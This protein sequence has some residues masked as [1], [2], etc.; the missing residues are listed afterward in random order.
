MLSWHGTEDVMTTS[1]TCTLMVS[2]D[3]S[4]ERPLHRGIVTFV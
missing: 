3:D 2:S 1:G 4:Q